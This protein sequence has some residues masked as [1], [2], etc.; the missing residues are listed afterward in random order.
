M[1]AHAVMNFFYEKRTSRSHKQRQTIRTVFPMVDARSSEPSRF[2]IHHRVHSN[3][4]Q[5]SEKRQRARRC[6]YREHSDA[7]VK[8]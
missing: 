7:K 3:L 8:I 6:F 1:R 4:L 5:K 2:T